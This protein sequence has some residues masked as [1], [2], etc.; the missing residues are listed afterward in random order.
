[1]SAINPFGIQMEWVS[2]VDTRMIDADK[3]PIPGSGEAVPCEC[4]GALHEVHAKVYEYGII[5]DG[6]GAIKRIRTAVLNYG[7]RCAKKHA[8]S[9]R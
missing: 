5:K 6:H 4:C 9:K 2:T 1:M 3:K 8:F 7:T